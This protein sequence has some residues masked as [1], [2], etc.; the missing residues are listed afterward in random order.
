VSTSS[1]P[2][3]T[4]S[5]IEQVIKGISSG[6]RLG[7]PIGIKC[8]VAGYKPVTKIWPL[9]VAYVLC[10]VFPALAGDSRIEMDTHFA[11]VDI[12]AAV[13]TLIATRQRQ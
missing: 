1:R 2:R 4:A 3:S 10:T 12:R 11:N 6:I 8:L 13:R 7:F 5:S 9:F